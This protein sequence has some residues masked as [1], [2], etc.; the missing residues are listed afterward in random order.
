RGGRRDRR[1]DVRRDGHGRRRRVE[2]R[3]PRAPVSAGAQGAQGLSAH[4]AAAL[5]LDDLRSH[6]RRAPAATVVLHPAPATALRLTLGRAE[7][8]Y[9][10]GDSLPPAWLALYFLPRV[11]ADA[12]R[13]DGSPPDTGVVAPVPL[14]RRL[15]AREPARV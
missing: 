6:I 13:P 8:E 12:L 10:E 11:A 2:P 4:A 3:R 1:D 9:R 14:P 15:F 5:D 7:P